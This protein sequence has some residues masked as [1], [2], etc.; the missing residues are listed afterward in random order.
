[1]ARSVRYLDCER[2]IAEQM[3]DKLEKWRMIEVGQANFEPEV[4][5]S[6]NLVLVA[7]WAPWSRPCGVL[8]AVL[9]EVIDL[10]A[11]NVK[12]VAINADDNPELSLWYGIESIPALL[13]FLH[14]ALHAKLVGTVS[15]QAILAKIQAI[16]QGDVPKPSP[17][18]GD[19]E[20]EHRHL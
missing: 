4:L 15:R 14:G 6:K 3:N 1:M 18:L 16:N 12:I 20:H 13:F 11:G 17:P 5:H 2:N 7:F 8:G 19:Q 10:C 9:N